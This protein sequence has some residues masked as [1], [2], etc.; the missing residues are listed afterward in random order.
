MTGVTPEAAQWSRVIPK[1]VLHAVGMARHDLRAGLAMGHGRSI[2]RKAEFWAALQS[3][4][5]VLHG[6]G[7]PFRAP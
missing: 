7:C 1:A 3:F 2:L 4:R 6:R 5:D